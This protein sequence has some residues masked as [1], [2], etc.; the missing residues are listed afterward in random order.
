MKHSTKAD[1]VAEYLRRAITNGRIRPGD[2]IVSEEIAKKLGVSRTPVREALKILEAGG[3]LNTKPHLGVRVT[4]FS[5]KD[6][7]DLSRVRQVLDGLAA[8]LAA[9]RLSEQERSKV[10]T[11]LTRLNDELVVALRAT[12]ATRAA[13]LN[14]DFHRQLYRGADSQLLFDMVNLSN[15]SWDLYPMADRYFWEMASRSEHIPQE[16]HEQHAAIIKAIEQGDSDAAWN[17]AREHIQASGY[18]M[19]EDERD[20]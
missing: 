3:Y 10:C 12:D 6:F 15:L 11:Q 8:Q 20:E 17:A 5:P 14:A 7:V 19:D 2:K 18:L 13:R 9:E 16:I 4:T 1:R